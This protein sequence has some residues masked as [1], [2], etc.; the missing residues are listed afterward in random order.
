MV[1]ANRHVA[2]GSESQSAECDSIWAEPVRHNF[3]SVFFVGPRTER[4]YI[5]IYG[6][7]CKRWEHDQ[8]A[9]MASLSDLG[10]RQVG[11]LFI[12]IYMCVYI[13]CTNRSDCT[14]S[15]I[16]IYIHMSLINWLLNSSCRS[17]L[18]P[19]A[20]LYSQYIYIYYIIYI[21]YIYSIYIFNIYIDLSIYI[22]SLKILVVRCKRAWSWSFIK[23]T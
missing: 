23:A 10:P 18:W 22:Y 8:K 12:Y 5:Y 7:H 11:A 16:Y 19:S 2:E 20:T 17:P 9:H 4:L 14:G 13:D 1:C 21:L 15:S 3:L 6:T